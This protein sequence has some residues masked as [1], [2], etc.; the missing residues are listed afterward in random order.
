MT[1]CST[2]TPGS[3]SR[4]PPAFPSSRKPTPPELRRSLQNRQPPRLPCKTVEIVCGCTP[5]AP[6]TARSTA[7]CPPHVRRVVRHAGTGELRGRLNGGHITLR[8]P[9]NDGTVLIFDHDRL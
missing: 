1:R 2:C 6:S 8:T 3:A 5:S 7:P 4:P 9:V